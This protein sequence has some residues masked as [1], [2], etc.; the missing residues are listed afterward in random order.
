MAMLAFS[1]YAMIWSR[2]TRM[3]EQAQFMV[4]IIVGV[5]YWAI[6]NRHKTRPI[7]ITVL[8]IL[9]AYFSHEEVFIILPAIVI[10]ALIASREGPY[11]FPSILTQRQWWI[12]ALIA[13]AIIS[14]QLSLVI[15]SHPPMFGTDQSLRPQVQITTDNVPYYFGLLFEPQALKDGPTPWTP[16]RPLLTVDSLL[17][18]LGCVIALQRKDRRACYCALFLIIST[19]TLVFVFTMKADR[20]YYPVLPVYYL[21]AAYGTWTVLHALWIFARPHLTLPHV[22]SSPSERLGI[23]SVS[24]RLTP[25]LRVALGGTVVLVFATILIVPMLPISNFNLFV[26]RALGIQYRRHFADYDNVAQ[27]MHNHM[28]PGDTVVSVAPAVIVLYEVGKVDDYFSVDRA[29]FLFERDG[30]L[31]ETTSGSHPLLNEAEFHSVLAE[32]NRI[33]LITDNGGYQGGVTKNGR[34]VF[35]PPDFHLV[36]EGYGSGIYFRSSTP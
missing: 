30:Q 29:L 12:S 5:L 24:H 19:V 8:C 25:L 17:A 13:I 21:M 26:S 35:P 6:Q 27:Y 31:M 28:R 14:T 34:F 7:R 10:C 3:Y 23:S 22:K 1:P 16:T 4:I 33:W 2:Q 15:L 18:V 32:H 9:L 36:Y 11:G 20:Y